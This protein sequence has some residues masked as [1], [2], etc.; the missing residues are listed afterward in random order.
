MKKILSVFLCLICLFSSMAVSASAS[1][2]EEIFVE[3]GAML[4]FEPDE[5]IG[6][7]IRYDSNKLLSGVKSVMYEPKPTVKLSNPGTY[8]VTE[9]FPLSVDHSFVCWEDSETGKY[10]Y[11]GDKIF[12]DGELTLY[13]VWEEKTD[14]NIRPVRVFLTAFQ[15]LKKTFQAFFGVF[16]VEFK[17]DLDAVPASWFDVEFYFTENDLNVGV[18]TGREFVLRVKVPEGVTYDNFDK[19]E[20]IFFGGKM[21]TVA[22]E[23][24]VYEKD[25]QGNYVTD[26]KGNRIITEVI[27]TTKQQ[28]VGSKEFSAA[29]TTM[30]EKEIFEVDYVDEEYQIINITLTDRVDN[31]LSGS[32]ITFYLPRGI[33]RY[34]DADGN[35]HYSNET[36]VTLF[37]SRNT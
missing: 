32:Y 11:P 14:N 24:Y 1:R 31:P 21:E 27:Y 13:A 28:L 4:G 8:T 5:P 36:S 17:E 29:Y 35:M 7:G 18:G 9:D 2:T 10:Y 12:I 15:A 19:T 30:G 20:P 33:L 23:E 6:Y 3:I 26:E 37:A 16:K 25:A 22:G 34:K